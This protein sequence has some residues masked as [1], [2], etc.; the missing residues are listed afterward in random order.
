MVDWVGRPRVMRGEREGMKAELGPVAL[1]R[2]GTRARG[3]GH[4]H[5]VGYGFVGAKPAVPCG[6]GFHQKGRT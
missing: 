4:P 3:G 5:S 2:V 6:R 1:S